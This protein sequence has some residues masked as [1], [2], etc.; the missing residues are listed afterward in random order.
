MI[1]AVNPG[2]QVPDHTEKLGTESR[3][4]REIICS[5]N[6]IK[7]SSLTDSYDRWYN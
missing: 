7:I 3:R 4:F 6:T 5:S 1:R 2:N